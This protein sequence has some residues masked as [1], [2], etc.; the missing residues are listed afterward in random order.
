MTSKI[1][2]CR[3]IYYSIFP[4]LLDMFRAILSLIIRSF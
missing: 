4:W 1:E 3:T 2:L